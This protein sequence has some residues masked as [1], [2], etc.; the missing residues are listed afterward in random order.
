VKIVIDS[1]LCSG[2]GRCVE[3]LPAVFEF[4]DAGFGRVRDNAAVPD[5][6]ELER[7]MALCPELAIS[8]AGD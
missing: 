6:K 7:A 2:H 3:L 1:A 8:V 4:D 5:P